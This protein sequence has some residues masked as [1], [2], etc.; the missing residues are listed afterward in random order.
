MSTL[1]PTVESTENSDSPELETTEPFLNPLEPVAWAVMIFF[2]LALAKDIT[3]REMDDVTKYLQ[4]LTGASLSI[5]GLISV[6]EKLIHSSS[7][8]KV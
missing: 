5:G 2:T 3:M 8:P 1:S 4:V 7:V 6:L